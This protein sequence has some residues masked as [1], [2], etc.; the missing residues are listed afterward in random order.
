MLLSKLRGFF[1]FFLKKRHS[2]IP[3]VALEGG[4]RDISP[5]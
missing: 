1:F 4:L 2:P 3:N 5:D